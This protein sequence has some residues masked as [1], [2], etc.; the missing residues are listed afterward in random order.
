MAAAA[1]VVG[2]SGSGHFGLGDGSRGD[3]RRCE[4]WRIAR[5]SPICGRVILSKA[6]RF[7]GEKNR[8]NYTDLP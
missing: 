5:D 2:R 1:V 6:L 4:R 3:R 8:V 7:V